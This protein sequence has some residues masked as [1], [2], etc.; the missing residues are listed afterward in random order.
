MTTV[1]EVLAPLE[2]EL[3][4]VEA[5]IA[6][7]VKDTGHPELAYI[8]EV[9]GKRLRPSLV[10]LTARLG[11]PDP[12]MVVNAAVG[13]EFLHVATLVHDDVIDNSDLR[14]GR[15]SLQKGIGRDRAIVVGDYYL[16]Q[17]LQCLSRLGDSGLVDRASGAIMRICHGE[18]TSV[19]AGDQPEVAEK[20]Y[21]E[22]TKAKTSAL[23]QVCT[24]AGSVAGNLTAEQAA[25]VDVYAKELGIAFQIVDDL[26][27]YVAEES[28]LGKPT[29]SDLREGTITLPLL[30]ALASGEN[31]EE[32][33]LL[34]AK[35]NLNNVDVQHAVQLVRRSSTLQGVWQEARAHADQAIASL[36]SFAPRPARESLEALCEAVAATR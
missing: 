17:G 20:A 18:L 28:V 22:K 10:I 5:A 3:G 13:V 36:T 12:T 19:G 23:L 35:T 4:E 33:R 7:E 31:G 1:G 15:P 24:V 21:F 26:L 2:T 16:A 32:L 11:E 8:G 30:R 14:R 27:D 34:A 6:A 29:G 25:S 9:K